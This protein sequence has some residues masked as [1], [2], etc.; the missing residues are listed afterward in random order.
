MGKRTD[1]IDRFADM[2]AEGLG[3][4]EIERRMQLPRR[5]GNALLQRLRKSLGE[6]AR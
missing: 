1:T 2:L 6:Q 4:S 3:I 5:Y